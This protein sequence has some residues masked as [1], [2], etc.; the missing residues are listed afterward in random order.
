MSTVRIPT[1]RPAV[2]GLDIHVGAVIVFGTV[3]IATSLHAMATSPLPFR[4]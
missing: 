3:A 1:R 2:S 4:R